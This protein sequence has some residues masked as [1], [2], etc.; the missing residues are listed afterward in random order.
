MVS[1]ATVSRFFRRL[2]YASFD[3]ARRDARRL[4]VS[5]S[6][7]YT[8][9]ARQSGAELIPAFAAQEASLLEETL[10]RIDPE[11]LAEIAAALAKAPRIRTLG[12]RNSQLIA[13][14]VTAQFAQIRP[15][16]APLL[17]PGQTL[18]EG[19]A[20]MQPGDVAVLIGFRRRPKDFT[21]IVK[22]LAQRGVQV[23][24]F[25]DQS[26]REAPALSAWTLDCVVMTP[27]FSDSYIGA[28]SVIRLL[29]IETM[30]CLG[31]AGQVHLET[32]EEL[33]AALSDLEGQG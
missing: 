23:L 31:E 7:L 16:V 19:I 21:A 32:I 33:H 2:G 12:Y 28:L 11:T 22:T 13:E 6:P 27:Q 24:L 14:Y 17:L 29:T 25:A 5:G 3:E 10:S 20:A 18:A 9:D 15:D 4:R 30:R 8:G 1:N 26:I